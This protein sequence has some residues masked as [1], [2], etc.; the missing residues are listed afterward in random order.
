MRFINMDFED[1]NNRISDRRNVFYWMTDRNISQ[2]EMRE[3]WQDKHRGITTS[4]LLELVN[5]EMKNRVKYIKEFDPN[6]QTNEGYIN[7]VHTAVLKDGKEIIIRCHPQGIKNGYFFAESLIAKTQ[8]EKGLPTYYTYAIH[9][10][11][12]K[13]DVAFQVIEKLQGT[14][15]TRYLKDYPEDME[16]I[17]FEAGKMMRKFHE[18]KVEGFGPLDNELAKTGILKGVHNKFIDFLRAG[19]T[20]ILDTLVEYN[21][22][23]KKQ[24]HFINNLYTDK[25]ELLDCQ[26]PCLIHNDYADWNLLTDG[27]EITGIIDLDE[28]VVSDPIADI[29]RWSSVSDYKRK[30]AF[31]NGYFEGKERPVNFEEKLNL[32]ALRYV[33]LSVANRCWRSEYIHTE[34]MKYLMDLGKSQLKY[35]LDFFVSKN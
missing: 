16:K 29:A 4:E 32:Y 35:L 21:I 24:S 33:I 1:I 26:N 3:I 14:T 2:K 6:D 9:E 13:Q 15:L 34:Q 20:H 19:L 10:L 25:N 30:G 22:I 23:T 8:R 18:V 27:K 5:R 7:S 28:C 11:K 31:L 12:D 17:M